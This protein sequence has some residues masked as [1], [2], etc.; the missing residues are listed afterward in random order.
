MAEYTG[1]DLRTW[2]DKNVDWK[3]DISAEFKKHLVDNDL[4]GYLTW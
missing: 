1:F 2:L 3:N 4:I